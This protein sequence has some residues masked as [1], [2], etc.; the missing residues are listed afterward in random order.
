MANTLN[1]PNI[2]NTINVLI[3][4]DVQNDFISQAGSETLDDIYININQIRN[5]AKLMDDKMNQMVMF[6]RDMHPLGH[7]SFKNY[8]P[9]CRNNL[10]VCENSQNMADDKMEPD[11][12]K[13]MTI[14][15]NF[16]ANK[17]KFNNSNDSKKT[18]LYNK[19]KEINSQSLNKTFPSEVQ[20]NEDLD[21]ACKNTILT[22][23]E[24]SNVKFS[25]ILTL[26]FEHFNNELNDICLFI[27]KYKVYTN[28]LTS[29][30][31][32]EPIIRKLPYDEQNLTEKYE[33]KKVPIKG[34]DLS[35]LF[36]G[37]QFSAAFARL[38]LN[39]EVY[40]TCINI[41]D[42]PT[43]YLE[44]PMLSKIKIDPSLVK[45]GE[46]VIEQLNKGEFCNY[47]SYSGFNY[48][49]KFEAGEI[50]NIDISQSVSTGLYERIIGLTEHFVRTYIKVN[51]IDLSNMINLKTITNDF[52]INITVCGLSG[53][54]SIIQGIVFW[55]KKYAPTYS[56]VI[57]NFI[58][59]ISGAIFLKSNKFGFK[60]SYELEDLTQDVLEQFRKYFDKIVER[61]E[62]TDSITFKINYLGNYIFTY[63]FTPTDTQQT[64]G[65]YKYNKY[66]QKYLN[67]SNKY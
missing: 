43:A 14:L 40:T 28:F 35:Y 62:F 10:R 22:Y 66:K 11:N 3:V 53:I 15:E 65:Y 31:S 17:I 60:Q 16:E 59:D 45:I 5:I 12:N 26:A 18:E 7:A 33:L 44:E 13:A 56:K 20:F 67:L 55:K 29:I 6:V 46:T 9:H 49:T 19:I 61:V 24:L 36:L 37:T 21:K 30:N 41:K 47:D 38:I 1:T 48:H 52:T 34:Y 63:T 8:R 25:E 32:K 64:I 2:P 42:Y 39:T 4:S 58:Y 57:I 27:K 54:Y 50:T 51:K 23:V